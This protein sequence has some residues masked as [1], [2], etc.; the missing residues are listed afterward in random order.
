MEHLRGCHIR[1]SQPETDMKRQRKRNQR[2]CWSAFVG[3]IVV[4]MT[5]TSALERMVRAMRAKRNRRSRIWPAL[6]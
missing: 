6:G 1:E 3:A 5:K 4:K 2:T